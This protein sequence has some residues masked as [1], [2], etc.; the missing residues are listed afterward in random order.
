MQIIIP[1]SGQGKRFVTAGYPQHKPKPL[2]EVDGKPMIYHVMDLFPGETNI[3]C[4][5]SEEHLQTTKMREVL[6]AYPNT[7]TNDPFHPCT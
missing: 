7:K 6:E 1:M 5:C 4:I 2:L 3:H